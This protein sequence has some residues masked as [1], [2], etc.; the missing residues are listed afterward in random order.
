MIKNNRLQGGYLFYGDEE[1]MKQ[2]CLNA[3]RKS[4]ISSDGN[5][6]NHIKLSADNFSLAYLSSMIETLP[7]FAEKKLIEIHSLDIAGMKESEL[8]EFTTLLAELPQYDYNVVI[9]YMLPDSFD[10]GT[11]KY[12]SKL[13][14]KLSEYLTPVGFDYEI[15]S[16]LIKWIQQHF[17]TSGI[18]I[19]PDICTKL[20]KNVGQSMFRLKNEIDKLSAYILS[21]GRNSVTESDID[22]ITVHIKSIDP[23]DFANAILDGDMDKAFY[24]LSDMKERKEKPEIIL[25]QVSRVYDDL[26]MIKSLYENGMSQQTIAVKLKM[27]E[28]K[29]GLYL[30]SSMKRSLSDIRK[31]VD[32]CFDADLKI[33]STALD[34]YAVL[35]RL[36]VELAYT[37]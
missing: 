31:A 13:F 22:N 21:Q 14:K 24:I 4:V 3:A 33:K 23:F 20:I 9:L 34:S 35:D 37:S 29:T 26:C 27:H 6:F 2:F 1:Y 10:F 12:P 36:V 16:R 19:E 8:E 32:L 25:S 17:R 7:V 5:I 15:P 30:K 18:V 11:A 28:Y